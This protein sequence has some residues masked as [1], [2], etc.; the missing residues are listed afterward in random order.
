MHSANFM[1][2]LRQL[3]WLAGLDILLV[4]WVIYHCLLLL[5]G[6]RASQ[7]LWGLLLLVLA[8][9]ASEWSGLSTLHWLLSLALPYLFIAII[10]LFQAEIRQGLA[11]I[12][13]RPLALRLFHAPGGDNYEDIV[14]AI[15]Y[16]SARSIG[17]LIVIERNTGLRTYAE[18][19]VA[20]D[21]RLNY[22]LLLALFNPAAPLHDGAVLVRGTRLAAAACFLP[23]STNPGISSHL[24]TRHRAAIGIT[25]ETD[26][27]AIVASEARGTIS[28]AVGGRLETDLSLDQLRARLSQLCG[29]YLPP[30]EIQPAPENGHLPAARPRA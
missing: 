10:V 18:S 28:L 16:L 21:A 2:A 14:L 26:A 7:V 8:F 4:A 25:E 23:I 22:D 15:H 9:Y 17:A 6:T 1:Q 13:R 30:V 20:L 24:G 29:Q 11:L 3:N 27:V 12:G 5:R 19:G